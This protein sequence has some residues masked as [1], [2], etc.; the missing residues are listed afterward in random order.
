MQHCSPEQLALAALREELPAEDAAHLDGCDACRAE[1][2]SLQRGVDALAVPA[3]SATGPEVA[4]PPR[5]WDAIAA[6][7]GATSL[8]R[9]AVTPTTEPPQAPATESPAATP[10]GEPPTADVLPLRPRSGGWSRSRWLTAAAAVL[11]GAVAGGTVVALTGD[12]AGG[13]VV[14]QAALDPLDERTASGRAQVRE[15]DGVRSLRI[16][17]DAPALDDG[18][19]EVWLLKPD[20]VRMVP[21]GSV[22]AGDTV[23]PLPEG[24]DLVSYPVV[25]VSIEPLDGDPTHSG[26][27]VVRGQLS[28]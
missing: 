27:S 3:F 11:V 6:A 4:P 7:T 24:L 21:L 16:D 14:A 15:A 10:G 1:V 2:A 17:L 13:S 19:Y 25:D 5:V 22:R 9:P 18:Y 28:R 26:V 23:L 8:P 12:D 20:A